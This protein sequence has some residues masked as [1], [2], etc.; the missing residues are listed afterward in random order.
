[1]EVDRD[2]VDSE[3]VRFNLCYPTLVMAFLER[4]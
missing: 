1:M 2:G 4:G 3:I